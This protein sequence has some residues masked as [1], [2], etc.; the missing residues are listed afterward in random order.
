MQTHWFVI[1][2]MMTLSIMTGAL[3]A[4]GAILVPFWRRSTSDAFLTWYQ[5]Y[6]A[7]LQ[8]FFAPLEIAATGAT[9]LAAA[10]AWMNQDPARWPLSLAAL[11]SLA[12]L[13]V[14][15]L[16]FQRA[17]ASFKNATIAVERVPHEL[18]IWSQWHWFRTVLSFAACCACAVSL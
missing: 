17:N 3:L 15:P 9:L 14:F 13:A 11:L 7:L 6:A 4:E 8:N 10:V 2:A 1:V 18:R 16:Y 12:V 5:K